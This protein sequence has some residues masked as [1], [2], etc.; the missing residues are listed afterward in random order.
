MKIRI[1][2]MPNVNLMSSFSRGKPHVPKGHRSPLAGVETVAQGV[3][4]S[5]ALKPSQITEVT[6]FL[7]AMSLVKC[8]H[9]GLIPGVGNRQRLIGISPHRTFGRLGE[10]P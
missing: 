5:D 6:R 9:R 7:E 2:S 1:C 10:H 8:R 4:P 3:V